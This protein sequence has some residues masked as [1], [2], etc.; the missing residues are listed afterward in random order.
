MENITNNLN[1]I[2]V[3]K[4][5][6]PL[7]FE[8]TSR[9]LPSNPRTLNLI[10]Q[11]REQALTSEEVENLVSPGA[12][13]L[14]PD[15]KDI[16]KSNTKYMF[17]NLWGETLLTY[18]FFSDENVKN[19]Q[20]LIRLAIHKEFNYVIDNQS[21]NELL[22]VMR[23]IFLE[24]SAHPPLPKANITEQEKQELYKK[25]TK[26]VNR[27]NKIVID[28]V[29]PRVATQLQQYLDYLRDASKINYQQEQPLNVSIKGQREYRSPTQ[30]WFGGD[31]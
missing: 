6:H 3:K 28:D 2:N 16:A 18:L 14:T 24:Y 25:Y 29:V 1:Q 12:Y 10:R 4:L 7:E 9:D 30:V 26:E 21:V 23:A 15:D 17:R 19:I 22:I 8:T 20:N 5:F 27:L 13:K 31:F 11:Q